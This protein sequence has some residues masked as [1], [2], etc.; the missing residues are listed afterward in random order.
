MEDQ[1]SLKE[2]KKRN[3]KA[4]IFSLILMLV[5]VLTFLVQTDIFILRNWWVIFILLPG[6]T[7]LYVALADYRANKGISFKAVVFF[8]LGS[9][10]NAVGV[11]LLFE[12]SWKVFWP[13]IIMFPG[14]GLIVSAF[15]LNK[16]YKQENRFQFLK[17]W[18]FAI[19]GATVIAALFIILSLT[20]TFTLNDYLP[21]WW[22]I[23]IMLISIGGVVNLV[24]Y[25]I[26]KVGKPNYFLF[27]FIVTLFFLLSG[28]FVFLRIHWG[29]LVATL[30]FITGF[31]I[32]LFQTIFGSSEEKSE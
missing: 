24:R 14:L 5:G 32:F 6:I 20:N 16:F 18:F 13:L 10:L 11:I 29:Y 3:P 21:R 28:L 7:F 23:L 22:G 30:L 31:F 9:V 12:L 19:G 15:F 25:F 8:L 17:I 27:H 26:M 4:I 1:R 2:Q